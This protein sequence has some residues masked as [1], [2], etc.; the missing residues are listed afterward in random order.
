MLTSSHKQLFL[1][2]KAQ[3]Y[4]VLDA[5]RVNLHTNY[6]KF[7]RTFNILPYDFTHGG[8]LTVNT[9]TYYNISGTQATYTKSVVHRLYIKRSSRGHI[10]TSLL[11]QT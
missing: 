5:H 8:F 6:N 3:N 7:L 9:Y 10:K 11:T 4:T 1:K 2:G